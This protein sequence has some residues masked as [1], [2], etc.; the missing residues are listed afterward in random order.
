MD[1]GAELRSR[2]QR[3]FRSVSLPSGAPTE[4]AT[5]G[6]RLFFETRVSADGRVGCVS[7]HLPE[8]W[9]TDGRA[10]AVGTFGRENPRNAP[11]VF[12]AGAQI[13][14]HWR[15][16]R[17]SLEDQA[18]RALLGPPSF[19]LESEEAAAERLKSLPGYPAAFQQAFPADSDPVS[20][21]NWAVA[22]AAYERTLA[23]P[24][25]FDAWLEG[26]SDAMDARATRGLAVFMDVGCAGCHRGQLLGGDA[27]EKFG[28]RRD[29]W[30]RTGSAKL[31]AG[32]FDATHEEADRYVF[33][34]A[35]LRNVAKT[36][37]YFHDG[38]VAS[39]SDAVTIMADVQLGRTLNADALQAVLGFLEALTGPV[40][41]NY[42]A[43][44]ADRTP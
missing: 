15:G 30:T 41:A 4:L 43:P 42:S 6:R 9:G 35:P 24:S 8:R 38:S 2:A 40:P 5:L 18:R 7:C 23:T 10:K 12:N 32:R 25:A 36:A 13:A 28:V 31:D 37:P 27:F 44:D 26:K 21:A 20:A 34:V 29:Y 14:Q 11:T 33:K 16:D 1:A 3:T 19:G 39:L 17:E 22:L